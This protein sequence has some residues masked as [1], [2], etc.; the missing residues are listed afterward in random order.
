MDGISILKQCISGAA[1]DDTRA[2]SIENM[3]DELADVQRWLE[4]RLVADAKPGDEE[5]LW[6]ECARRFGL[7]AEQALKELDDCHNELVK[8]RQA[9]QAV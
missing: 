4:L 1:I 8:T 2:R 9:E 6:V 3:C 5:L 7:V